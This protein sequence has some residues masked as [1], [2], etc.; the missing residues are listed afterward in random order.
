MSFLPGSFFWLGS[1]VNPSL[2]WSMGNAGKGRFHIT[3]P[4]DF[5]WY[6]EQPCKKFQSIRHHKERKGL[7]HEFIVLELVDGSICRIERMGDP[8]ARFEAIRAQGTVAYDMAQSFLPDEFANACL[9]TS[10]IVARIT[11]PAPLDL[12]D[13]LRICRAIHEGEKTCNYTLQGFNCY[14]FALAIQAVL[15]A[16]VRKWEKNFTGWR[17]GVE[18][19]LSVLSLLYESQPSNQE[20]QPFILRMYSFLKLEMC[21]PAR[22]VLSNL[23]QVLYSPDVAAEVNKA[24][25]AV[26]WHSHLELAIDYVLCRRVRDVVTRVLLSHRD[27]RIAQDL[28]ADPDYKG[29]NRCAD[30]MLDLVSQ[31][32]LIHEKDLRKSKLDHLQRHIRLYRECQP[33]DSVRSWLAHTIEGLNLYQTAAK[34]QPSQPDIPPLSAL[35]RA[36][37]L[38]PQPKPPQQHTSQSQPPLQ[39]ASKPSILPMSRIKILISWLIYAR[40]II[41]WVLHIVLGLFYITLIDPAQPC[42]CVAVEEELKVALLGYDEELPYEGQVLDVG[43]VLVQKLRSLINSLEPLHWNDWP[44]DHVYQP[45]RKQILDRVLEE[46]NKSIIVSLQNSSDVAM[47][48]SE[49]QERLLERIQLHSERVESFR[50]GNAAHIR[51]ELED[52]M[53][54]VWALIRNN[55]DKECELE[56]LSYK[57]G[58]K[59]LTSHVASV[60]SQPISRGGFGDVYRGKLIGGSAIALK[61]MRLPLQER[62]GEGR[63]PLRDAAREAHIWSKCRHPNVLPLLGLAEVRGEIQLISPW[64]SNGTLPEYLGRHPECVQICKGISYLHQGGIIHGDVKGSNVLVSGEGLPLLTDFGTS[65]LTKLRAHA[66]DEPG[67]SLRWAAPERFNDSTSSVEA[68]IYAL[69]MTILEILTSKI[70]HHEKRDAAVLSAVFMKKE[71]PKR[72][73]QIPPDS[74]H[75]D[76][77]WSLLQSC[78]TYDPSERPIAAEVAEI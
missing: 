47:S 67:I 58:C 48:V 17:L 10:D 4:L 71:T 21:W 76:T 36:P 78:W 56:Y 9:D 73:E 3:V 15:T 38:I 57:L 8:N 43:T 53:S 65:W 42:L 28:S 63:N 72:P 54:Q 41:F 27:K 74:E 30:L 22:D 31:A 26:L 77:L 64:M 44:W 66:N 34:L 62:D 51:S 46:K 39:P 33:F 1:S 20:Q 37:Q 6:H 70:P 55:D 5:S 49:F 29:K 14:F 75:G 11:F 50:L 24:L 25:N 7:Q 59:N 68:D 13:V 23:E 16:L 35:L 61:A 19:G 12:M 45:I 69:G 52:K 40:I 2:A 32:A 18:E 60:D